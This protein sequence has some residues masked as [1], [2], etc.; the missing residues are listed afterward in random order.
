MTILTEYMQRL[1]RI[2]FIFISFSCFATVWEA[3]FLSISEIQKKWPSKPFTVE[4]FRTA[5]RLGRAEMSAD[6]IRRGLYV[7]EKLKTVEKD[8]GTPNGKFETHRAPA[9]RIGENE[10]LLVFLPDFS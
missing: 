1:S 5:D 4:S 10:D 2:V 3:S 9:Y 6:L 8:L 7:G